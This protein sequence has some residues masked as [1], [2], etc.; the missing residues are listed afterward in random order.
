MF[1]AHGRSLGQGALYLMPGIG[2]GRIGLCHG[3]SEFLGIEEGV[4]D[5]GFACMVGMEKWDGWEWF[6]LVCYRWMVYCK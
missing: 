3:I 1:S 6:P 2:L 4:S 5:W